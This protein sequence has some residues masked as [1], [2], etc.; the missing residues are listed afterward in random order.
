[1]KRLL[2]R[3]VG[4]A[5]LV[6]VPGLAM[7]SATVLYQDQ[8]IGVTDTLADPNDLWI[9]PGDLT[10]V[11]GF[12]LKPE[13]ACLDEICVPVKQD[14]DSAIFITRGEDQ[15]FNVTELARRLQQ[16][17]VADHDAA[18]WSFGAV[19]ATRESFLQR[20]I[21]PDFALKDR[22]G[23]EVTLADYDGMKILLLTWASW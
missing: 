3:L 1:M 6:A 19:P 12:E 2:G 21:A 23:R 14:E 22:R 7:S 16:P 13:G 15:W 4:L 8:A 17:F 20:G 18:I 5:A 9:P 10:R 11:N